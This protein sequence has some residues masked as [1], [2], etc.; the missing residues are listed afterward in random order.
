MQIGRIGSVATTAYQVGM[1]MGAGV[2]GVTSDALSNAT[3]GVPVGGVSDASAE[4]KPGYKSSPAE[5]QTCKE[6]KYIDG[7]DENVSF[8]SAA[9]ISPEAAMGTVRAHEGE[10]V[11][12]AYKKA[13]QGNG[14]VVNASVSIHTSVCPECGRTYV[15]GGTTSTTIRY[16][17]SNPYGRNQ[18]SLDGAKLIGGK[19]D[20]SI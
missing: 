5:C 4:V 13:A 11:S 9:H 3:G 14:Q 10:H 2:T 8:K 15:S 17:E 20:F 1:T 18:K 6:R 16:N 19:M 7:S 12:N